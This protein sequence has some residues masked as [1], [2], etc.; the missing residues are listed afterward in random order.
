MNHGQK[1]EDTLEGVCH[2]LF[3]G[4]FVLRSPSLIDPSGTTELADFFVLIDDTAIIF[5]SKSLSCDVTDLNDIKFGRI[6]KKYEHAKKQLNTALNAHNRGAEVR[7]VSPLDIAFTLDWSVIHKRIGIVTLNVNDHAYE[8]PEFRFQFPQLVEEHRGIMVHTF[9]LADLVRMLDELST[10]ADVLL[11][12]TTREKAFGCGRVI[13]SN[14]LDL[15]AFSKA[16]YPQLEKVFSD[17]SFHIVVAPGFWEDFR[18]SYD[19]RII[20]RD[21][22]FKS[23]WLIDQLIREMHTAVDFTAEQYELTLQ[24]S[25]VQYLKLIGKLGKLTRME[26]AEVSQKLF[27]KMEK[28]KKSKWGYFIYA[29]VLANTA[30]LFL[31]FNEED[32]EKRKAFLEN[33]CLEACH[34]VSESCLIGIATGGAQSSSISTDAI[35]LDVT[36]VKRKVSFSK[37]QFFKKPERKSIT[38]WGPQQ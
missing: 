2:R 14:E 16:D 12:L 19:E 4:D 22:R 38:E 3:G 1:A 11:Y 20:E 8:D 24:Q 7:A 35:L 32:R 33:L 17:P 21:N 25:V 5:Q 37:F 27:E 18:S 6:R 36:E 28:T 9:I 26:R 10:P 30:F 29:S 34:L 13:I 31:L 15:L 23:S